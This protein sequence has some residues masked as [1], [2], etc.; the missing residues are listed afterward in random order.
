MLKEVVVAGGF[1]ILREI[2]QAL[3]LLL[4]FILYWLPASVFRCLPLSIKSLVRQGRRLVFKTGLGAEQKIELAMTE[5]TAGMS[6]NKLHPEGVQV[7]RGQFSLLSQFLDIYD[8]LLLV[9]QELHYLD[10]LNLACVSKSVRESVL[11]EQDLR[12]RLGVFKMYTCLEDSNAKCCWTCTN[13]ICSVIISTATR[14]YGLLTLLQGCQ[15]LRLLRQTKL[16]HHLDN[17]HPYC[18]SCFNTYILRHR[19]APGERLENPE[20]Q[21]APVTS[22][23]NI[24]QLYYHGPAYY[25]K[26]QAKL[27]KIDRAVCRTC[28]LKTDDELLESKEK[29]IRS[30]LMVGM[31]SKG[32]K[33]ITCAKPGCK[34]PLGNGP[35][36]WIC[37]RLSCGKECSSFV[38]KAWGRNDAGKDDCF[39]GEAAV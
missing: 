17:C 38:H 2:P 28:H 37:K 4:G 32:E 16:L 1:L 7:G 3:I 39:F 19:P 35:R 14:Y 25:K 21:C 8:M 31:T 33:W 34:N 15:Q 27:P 20:C 6:I 13:Q 18:T 36:W 30:D 11:P 22:R 29:T 10:V 12:R 5:L 26:S 23:P 9:T 24:F